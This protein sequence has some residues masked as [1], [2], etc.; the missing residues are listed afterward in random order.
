[1]QDGWGMERAEVEDSAGQSDGPIEAIPAPD[2]PLRSGEP[3]DRPASWKIEVVVDDSGQWESDPFRFET[4]DEALAY[5]R[6][7]E[8]RWAAVRDRRVMKSHD[9]VNQHWPQ[10]QKS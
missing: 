5:A 2:V 7:L 10:S 9:P 6:D 8:F 4:L 1:M 3:A